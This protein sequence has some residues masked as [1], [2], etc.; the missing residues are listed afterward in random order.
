MGFSE[1]IKEVRIQ[2]GLTQEQ[3]G[4]MFSKAGS[5]VR[6]WELGNSMPTCKLLIEI[7][8]KTD[9]S[10]DYILGIAEEQ[11][12]EAYEENN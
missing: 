11:R 9:I 10:S 7:S 2:K 5:T 3:F 1:R 6:S 12:R 4:A 8:K